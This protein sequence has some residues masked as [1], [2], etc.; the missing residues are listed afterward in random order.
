MIFYFFLLWWV[1]IIIYLSSNL[2]IYF[3]KFSSRCFWDQKVWKWNT[4]IR[5]RS[6]WTCMF[7]CICSFSY[8]NFQAG[9]L[10]NGFFSLICGRKK[11]LFLFVFSIF[12]IDDIWSREELYSWSFSPYNIDWEFLC[13]IVT[14]NDISGLVSQLKD[15]QKR[16][17]ELEEGNK[18]LSSKVLLL[19]SCTFRHF[20][21]FTSYILLFEFVQNCIGFDCPHFLT[22]NV[23]SFSF[24]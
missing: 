18:L 4:V 20:G 6:L 13:D 3:F 19:L 16:N 7:S 1:K 22:R 15:M 5:G 23:V 8:I 10:G 2:I 12:F 11:K 24:K 9:V 21:S 17:M 14:Q